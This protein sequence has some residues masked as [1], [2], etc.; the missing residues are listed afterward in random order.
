MRQPIVFGKYLLLERISVG[1]MAEVFKAKSF[2]EEGFEKILAIK[3]ILPSMAEDEEFIE[4]FIDEAK[5]S[6]QLSHPNIGQIFE[7]GKI[8]SSYFI[9]M[10]YVWGKDVLQ[11]QN[12]FRRHRQTMPLAMSVFIA[13]RV[14]EGLDYAHRKKDETNSPLHIIH[15]DVSP[16]NVLVSYSG[17]CKIIDFGIAKARSRSSKTQAGVLKGKFGYMSPEQVRALPLDQRSD[18]FTIGTV[19][20]EMCTGERLF[21]GES[22]FATLE[23]VRNA[24]VKAPSKINPKI[25]PALEGIIMQALRRDP[26][27]R[28]QWASEM[29]EALT[30]FLMKLSPIFTTKNLAATVSKLF[31]T[32]RR[33][34]QKALEGYKRIKAGDLDAMSTPAAARREMAISL[35]PQGP[36]PSYGDDLDDF[37]ADE[38]TEIGGPAFAMIS[39]E[40]VEEAHVLSEMDMEEIGAEDDELGEDK[41]A[42]FSEGGGAGVA[43]QPMASEPTFIF[44]MESGQMVQMAEQPTVIFANG[45]N[46]GG[47]ASAMDLPD[48]GPTVIFDASLGAAVRQGTSEIVVTAPV[49]APRKS[50]SMVKDILIGVLVAMVVILGI[51]TWRVVSTRSSTP[52]L[53]KAATLVVST[54][55]SRAATVLIDGV[56]RGEITAGTPL[57][58]EGLSPLKAL[59]IK[60]LPKGLDPVLRTVT[61]KP[62]QVKVFNVELKVPSPSGHLRLTI[63][64]PG[65]KVYL[66]GA[67]VSSASLEKPLQLRAGKEHEVRVELEGFVS[68]ILKVKLKSGEKVER[69]INLERTDKAALRFTT[70]PPGAEVLIN[71]EKRGVTPLKIEG[72]NPGRYWIKIRLDG[73][74]TKTE[75]MAAHKGKLTEVAFE[76]KAKQAPAAAAAAVVSTEPVASPTPKAEPKPKTKL[77]VAARPKTA[78]KPRTRKPRKKPRRDRPKAASKEEKPAGNVGY[79]VANTIPWAKVLVDNRDTGKTTPVAPRSKISLKPG[80]HKVTF[81]VDGKKF[82]FNI[83]VTAGKIT[84][85]IKKLPVD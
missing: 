21:T 35:L 1:G 17:E 81:V 31:E 3:R 20:Y 82:T 9:A 29:Q 70:T 56:K 11:I 28:F 48:Q 84:R 44:N 51:V 15:R 2:G 7:L 57:P 54:T 50:P 80:R 67:E 72:L 36:P 40:E 68:S 59:A 76:L 71:G 12:R 75:V 41:T 13:S 43:G 4:M 45:G 46:G 66:D 65:A 64:P 24:I 14:C 77:K 78:T 38:K 63:N 25:S 27:E 39:E 33:R 18:I 22:D 49:D 79:L 53:P 34:E 69:D 23:K 30:A 55:P 19:L 8:D 58:I 73:Y 16:Q 5:I 42:I 62:G 61:L 47:A 10:E 6:G 52:A 37:E 83:K 60:L 32:E 85:L 74:V 26:E